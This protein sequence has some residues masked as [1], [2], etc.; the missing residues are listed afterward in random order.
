M[1]LPVIK[2]ILLCTRISTDSKIP[3]HDTESDSPTT[4]I[5]GF[6]SFKPFDNILNQ[7]ELLFSKQEHIVN[8]SQPENCCVE[9]KRQTN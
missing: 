4:D 6:I 1:S 5:K 9:Q 7:H 2:Y 8:L 3:N